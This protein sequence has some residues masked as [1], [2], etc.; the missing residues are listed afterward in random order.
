M[1]VSKWVRIG[2]TISKREFKTLD[3]RSISHSSRNM[4]KYK[5]PTCK[6]VKHISEFHDKDFNMYKTCKKCLKNK[7]KEKQLKYIKKFIN[8][9]LNKKCKRIDIRSNTKK[10]KYDIKNHTKLEIS[11]NII[12]NI[13]K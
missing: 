11:K 9:T 12:K 13:T 5:C 3:L 7:E 2:R 1:S 8:K 10:D 6:C 4:I